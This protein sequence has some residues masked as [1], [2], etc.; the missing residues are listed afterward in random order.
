MENNIQKWFIIQ[1]DS[2]L[3][4][5]SVEVLHQMHQKGHIDDETILWSE[6]NKIT[7][8]YSDIFL[9][10][11]MLSEVEIDL[12]LDEDELPPEIPVDA[13]VKPKEI[14]VK[15]LDTETTPKPPSEK[16]KT[17]KKIVVLGL[18]L[19]IFLGSFISLY[20]VQE[21]VK[22]T[23]PS[24]MKLSDF[25]IAFN[26]LKMNKPSFFLSKDRKEVFFTTS[27]QGELV[28]GVKLDSIVRESLSEDP[29]S[30]TATAVLKDN[31]ATIKNFSFQKGDALVEGE[32]EIELTTLESKHLPFPYSFFNEKK[33]IN[34]KEKV[35]LTNLSAN[36]FNKEKDRFW[37]SIRENELIFWQDL[38]EQYQ[39]LSVIILQIKDSLENVFV[40]SSSLG[41]AVKRFEKNYKENFGMFFTSFVISNDKN[42][43]K[44]ASQD[45]P[46]K[47]K[48]LGHYSHLSRLAKAVG[49]ETMEI[50][51][52]L[53]T[54]R[55]YNN[56]NETDVKK[57]SLNRLEVLLKEAKER[58]AHIK[59]NY[60]E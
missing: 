35:L 1:E 57:K 56:L 31:L 59:T 20:F 6:Q 47:V 60:L 40:L 51:H 54:F 30:V 12:E 4:P 29:V 17:S 44:L 39:T 37:K 13:V 28:L 42:S 19:I 23:R 45:F 11:E 18:F 43:E 7:S 25:E 52:D 48:V 10:D 53:E 21:K 55:N 8:S 27:Y 34:L 38:T 41:E 3:G 46:D 24:G 5:Y 22:L 15:N 50:L 58:E 33:V 14:H 32:Y 36:D 2:H 16:K 49:S 9:V 26:N